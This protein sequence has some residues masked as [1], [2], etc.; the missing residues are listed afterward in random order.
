VEVTDKEI[1]QIKIN[2]VPKNTK[3]LCKKNT[4][5]IVHP[6]GS[7]II[8]EYSPCILLGEYSSIITSPLANNC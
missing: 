4:K 5:T 6:S 1:S 3:D 8:W 2:P 7:V